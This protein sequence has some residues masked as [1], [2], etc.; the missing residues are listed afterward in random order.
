MQH[1]E[2]ETV[3]IRHGMTQSVFIKSV[4]SQI[5]VTTYQDRSLGGLHGLL[6]TAMWEVWNVTEVLFW[7]KAFCCLHSKLLRH[8]ITSLDFRRIYNWTEDR[9]TALYFILS[10]LNI[11]VVWRGGL[12]SSSAIKHGRKCCCA[13]GHSDLLPFIHCWVKYRW[14]E[15]IFMGS[16]V[17]QRRAF[18][19]ADEEW[20]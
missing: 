19:F 13:V 4:S 20:K 6:K 7:S 14:T 11:I 17:L 1:E 10:V 16:R 3:H 5:S 15:V 8:I 9:R 18:T 2:R 12:R